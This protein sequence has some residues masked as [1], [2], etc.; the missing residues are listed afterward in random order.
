MNVGH[1]HTQLPS[2]SLGALINEGPSSFRALIPCVA[3]L[4]KLEF[5]QS[6][7]GSLLEQVQRHVAFT[8]AAGPRH[9][10]CSPCV[11]LAMR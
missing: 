8:G 9:V 6:V 5:L 11:L 4:L 10:S 7:V 3:H 1:A 2:S